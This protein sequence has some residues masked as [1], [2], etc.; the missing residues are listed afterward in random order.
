MGDVSAA[1]NAFRKLD[2]KDGLK[3]NWKSAWK[4][5]KLELSQTKKVAVEGVQAI[6]E[7]SRLYSAAVGAPGLIP[8][9]YLSNNLMPLTSTIL[10]E[11]ARQALSDMSSMQSKGK[12]K[13][14]RKI[15]LS[16]FTAGKRP[17]TFKAARFFDVDD[18]IAF[19]YD[20]EWN[21]ELEATLQVFATPLLG[22]ARIP[23]KLKNLQFD[24]TV[25]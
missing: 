14:F 4:I 12:I 25:R 6:R 20:L 1:E 15:T 13:T 9:Q 16:S 10:Q 3:W 24:G 8:I 5:L 19:D 11:S 7:E 17:P 21:S 22:M 23:I 2:I 18:S